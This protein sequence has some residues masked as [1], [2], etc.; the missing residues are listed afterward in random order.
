VLR[1]RSGWMVLFVGLSACGASGGAQTTSTDTYQEYTCPEP[2]GKIVR[3]DCS[4]IAL[5][6]EGDNVEG[7]VGVGNLGASGS[8]K[9]EAIREA[10]QLVQVLKEQ[11]V[12]LCNDFNTCKLTVAE[13]GAQKR[14]LDDSYVGL[15]AIRDRLKD[16]D[17]EGAVRLL[18]Q[19]RAMSRGVQNGPAT[20]SA[21][22]E[23]AAAT[24]PASPAGTTAGTPAATPVAATT[25]A[26]APAPAAADAYCNGM[27]LQLARRG[28]GAGPNY[29][30]PQ[31]RGA[32]KGHPELKGSKFHEYLLETQTLNGMKQ[33]YVLIAVVPSIDVGEKLRTVVRTVNQSSGQDI[34]CPAIAPTRTIDIDLN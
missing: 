2:I 21:A 7:S 3:E 22:P 15:L 6:Y 9:R 19:V 1:A 20:A 34:G 27:A 17:A 18:E 28:T 10:D 16:V 25:A 26:A 5:S 31:M 4:R 33:E 23:S 24:T 14:G 11:R 29:A 30:Y 12:G 32:L 8:Y 13:Y